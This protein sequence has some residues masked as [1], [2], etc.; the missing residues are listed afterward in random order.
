MSVNE[1][2]AFEFE[3]LKQRITELEAKN[4]RVLAE[5]AKFLKLIAEERVKYEA[6]NA[7]LKGRIEKLEKSRAD[8]DA[9]NAKRDVVNAKLKDR[10]VK[11]EQDYGQVQS[12]SMPL[13]SLFTRSKP[14]VIPDCETKDA[15]PKVQF[16]TNNLI[17]ANSKTSE[18]RKMDAFLDG[19]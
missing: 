17:S 19:A 3:V 15:V 4:S 13:V 14:V 5:K 18:D 6:E 10:V 16:F 1:S 8:A 12:D 7:K 11:L 2:N 9:K